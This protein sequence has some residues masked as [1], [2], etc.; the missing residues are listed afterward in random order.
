MT[1]NPNQII[2]GGTPAQLRRIVFGDADETITIPSN[3]V[4]TGTILTSS[5]TD[6]F[7][8]SL[9]SITGIA[10]PAIASA[11]AW[12]AF[13]SS[14]NG[15]VLMGSGSTYDVT[16]LNQ[17]G[18]AV[19]GVTKNTTGLVATG[20]VNVTGV[21]TLSSAAS[22]GGVLTASSALTVA[23]VLTAS[24]ATTLAGVTTAKNSVL[25]NASS[26]AINAIGYGIGYTTGAGSSAS[27][28][29]ATG[30][31]AAFTLNTPT[32]QITFSNSAMAAY[33]SS[34]CTWTCSAL[35][36]YDVVAINHIAGGTL[37]AY[38]FSVA[39]SNGQ[40]QFIVRNIT[41][42]SLT[43]APVVQYAIVKGAV[44]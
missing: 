15:A 4:F 42:G 32:G 18:T 3:V 2:V 11:V 13:A 22:V 8:S 10:T 14:V 12:V 26:A 37:G 34:S 17:A 20:A 38:N 33:T 27:Q 31:T 23:G 24:S 21:A 39:A 7:Q 44:A 19:L 16:L 5:I 29:G 9:V 6:T 1:I 36:S 25:F 30:K 28:V 43:E 35:Q 40:G 41:S